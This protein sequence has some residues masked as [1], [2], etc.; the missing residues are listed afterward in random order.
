MDAGLLFYLARRTS[1]CQKLLGKTFGWFGVRVGPVRVCTEKTRINRGMAALLHECRTVFL[2]G[3]EEAGRPACAAHIF[4]TLHIPTD[5]SGEPLGVRK[6]RGSAVTGYLI[7]SRTQ[8]IALLPDD[9]CEIL[10]MLPPLCERLKQKFHLEGE[11][12][13]LPH[14]NFEKLLAE[15]MERPEDAVS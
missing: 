15:A 12:P 4:Q 6:L 3:T 1:V 8:A 14:P 2:V 5:R 7:E 11:I 13:E 10:K 9:P